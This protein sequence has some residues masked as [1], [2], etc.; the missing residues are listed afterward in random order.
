M[1]CVLLQSAGQETGLFFHP[2][3]VA[4][5]VNRWTFDQ[6]NEWGDQFYKTLEVFLVMISQDGQIKK[7]MPNWPII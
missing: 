6:E 5:G 3:N 2:E 7:P 4:Q 1:S